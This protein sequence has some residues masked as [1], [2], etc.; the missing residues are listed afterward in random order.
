MTDYPQRW[1]DAAAHESEKPQDKMEQRFTSVNGYLYTPPEHNA[2]SFSQEITQEQPME[3]QQTAKL[4]PLQAQTPPT[5][6][7]ERSLPSIGDATG[8]ASNDEPLYPARRADRARSQTPLFGA[9]RSPSIPPAVPAPS[10]EDV[11]QD[12]LSKLL[13]GRPRPAAS[14]YTPSEYFPSNLGVT[15][16]REA[17]IYYFSRVNELQAIRKAKRTA[18]LPS[19]KKTR[20]PERDEFTRQ[21]LDRISGQVRVTKPRSQPKPTSKARAVSAS[22]A[23][24]PVQRTSTPR[25]RT[26]KARTLSEFHDTAFPTQEKKHKRAPPSKKVE[27]N[28]PW[29][30]MDNYAPPT[31]TLDTNG[32]AL[33]AYWQG[34]NLLD[35]SADPDRHELHPQE[36]NVA[37]TLRL[38]CA[39]YMTNKRKIFKSKLE[40]LR[41]GKNFTKTAAQGACSIDVNKA[42]QLHEAFTRV[43]WLENSWFE[44][45]L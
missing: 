24:S 22:A 31:N 36:V 33:K 32:K 20:S 27:D 15:T 23:T 28:T 7:A 40:Y 1:P 6:P 5:S 17:L 41:E 2:D 34:A 13:I 25:R 19:P 29:H 18:K 12:M 16:G 3:W 42:S 11:G 26:P 45:W 38:T 44:K 9:D 30:E 35:L 8:Y 43:G 37:S 21:Q 39:Q 10:G 4:A 14:K